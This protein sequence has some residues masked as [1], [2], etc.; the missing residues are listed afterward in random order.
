MEINAILAGLFVG[1]IL[2]LT[3]VEAYT[4]ANGLPT[5]SERLQNLGRSVPLVTV[6][7]SSLIG[8]LLVH[9]FG[10]TC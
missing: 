8:M 4:A 6:I 5:I 10:G 9:F 3:A 7:V 1:F 2:T